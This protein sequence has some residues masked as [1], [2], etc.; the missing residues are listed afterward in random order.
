MKVTLG[1]G[2]V[3]IVLASVAASIGFWS[4]VGVPATLIIIEVIPFLV[5]AIGVD[6]IFI[7]V[8][9]YQMDNLRE[10]SSQ[11]SRV[12][13]QSIGASTNGHTEES[14][15][16]L[17]EI[18]HG[19]QFDLRSEVQ[20]RV[21]RS[22]GR[23]GPSMLLSSAAESVAFFCGS[24][25]SMPAVRVFALYAGVSLVINFLLQIFAFTAL[26]T[27]DA[28]REAARKW[29]VLCCV[30]NR[31]PES[32]IQPPNETSGE[33]HDR[34]QSQ[35]QQPDDRR[36]GAQPHGTWLYQ[37]V[38][39]YL[40]P[41]ILSRWIRPMLMI[42]LL[43]WMCVCVALITTRLEVGLDQR[44]SMPLDSYVLD[45]F[46][47]ISQYLAVGPPVYFVVTA[48]HNYTQWEPGQQE[49]CGLS[50]CSSTS[51]PSV[52]GAYAHLANRSYIASPSMVWTDQYSQ[53]LRPNSSNIHCCRVL[54]SDPHHFCDASDYTSD[55][56]SC[57]QSDELFPQGEEFN[58]FIGRFLQQNPDEVCP[59]G[60]KA[61]FASSV[62]LIKRNN[63]P[64][65]VS[66]GATNF[67]TY[68]TVLKRPSDYLEALKLS[69]HIADYALRYWSDHSAKSSVS[70][71][72]I[73]PYS[74]FYVFYEQYLGMQA[75]TA[76]QLGVCLAA[77]TVIVLLLLGLNF[78]ATFAVLLGVVCIDVSLVGLMSIWDINLNAISLVNLVVCTGIA[79][80][81]C[82]HIVR[83]YTVSARKTRIERAH[84]SLSE[85]GSS[86]LRGITL[87]KLGG[88]L[89]LAFSN[90]RLFQVFYFRMYLGIVVFGALVGLIFLPVL[91]SYIGPSLNP[92][93]V[94]AERERRDSS[95]GGNEEI[96]Q[97][98]EMREE[99]QGESQ[100]QATGCGSNRL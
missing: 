92:F 52:I 56:V 36:D 82:A 26:L 49:V 76:L 24:L 83:A 50:S 3:L 17:L 88:I 1:L 90:S 97:E 11:S 47:A 27:L 7:L 23:V 63:T 81:F 44:L 93:A 18:I 67:M 35:E 2:G 96:A 98:S 6:N 21:A 48:G 95:N 59:S 28:R 46:D 77:I 40:S 38:S 34:Y 39:N 43:A 94:N 5:L 80:E 16:R 99:G 10:A 72:T 55:C 54:K 87:T 53:W 32:T 20:K 91:L 8:Q 84:E 100:F 79:V 14:G 25:T 33:E 31:T 62:Q 58:R 85:M 60:G 66:V 9:D 29:D 57:L 69:R 45:Y 42:I 41:F 37:A 75:E 12:Q 89:V 68:H 71:N 19:S 13:Q 70:N 15:A 86:V 4:F 65:N 61:A 30:R 74:V 78:A 73:F 51:L 22:L 64:S